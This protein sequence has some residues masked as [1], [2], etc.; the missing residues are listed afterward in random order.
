[1]ARPFFVGSSREEIGAMAV[2]CGDV[3]SASLPVRGL[4]E[5]TADCPGIALADSFHP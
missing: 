4:E 5:G 3:S 2:R 1:M